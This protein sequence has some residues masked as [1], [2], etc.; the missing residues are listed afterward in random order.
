MY[1][2]TSEFSIYSQIAP[3]QDHLRL[4]ASAFLE[5]IHFLFHLLGF[6]KSRYTMKAQYLL[7]WLTCGLSITLALPYSRNITFDSQQAASRQLSMWQND[8]NAQVAE[9]LR[10]R[11]TVAKNTT[12]MSSCTAD[13][14]IYRREWW[15]VTPK[16]R[17]IVPTLTTGGLCPQAIEKIT[18]MQSNVL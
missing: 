3:E 6:S 16:L 12:V 15:V 5:N 2:I 11:Q 8:L 7:S 4:I 13:K 14:I 10:I 1:E 17:D 9:T 18:S